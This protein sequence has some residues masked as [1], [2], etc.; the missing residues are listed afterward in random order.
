[1][2]ALRTDSDDAG[3]CRDDRR[4][5]IEGP[6]AAKKQ[7]SQHWFYHART[8][9]C[10]WAEHVVAGDEVAQTAVLQRGQRVDVTVAREDADAAAAA[11][12]FLQQVARPAGRPGLGDERLLQHVQAPAEVR[13]GDRAP[14]STDLSLSGLL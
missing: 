4:R 11:G 8:D 10:V 7:V 2:L 3:A 14:R 6:A 12:E 5:W 13:G 1:M 9:R